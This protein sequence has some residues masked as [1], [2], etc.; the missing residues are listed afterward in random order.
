MNSTQIVD[1]ESYYHKGKK[2]APLNAF[3][4]GSATIISIIFLT[5]AFIQKTEADKTR[6]ELMHVKVEAEMQMHQ[7]NQQVMAAQ[8]EAEKQ[9]MLMVRTEE[10]LQQCQTA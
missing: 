10:L 1:F 3:V 9:R 6:A 8:R 7:A 5:F 2:R 4:L